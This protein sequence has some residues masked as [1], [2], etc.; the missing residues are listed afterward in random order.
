MLK[1]QESR[2]KGQGVSVARIKDQEARSKNQGKD[3]DK[4][5]VQVLSEGQADLFGVPLRPPVIYHLQHRRCAVIMRLVTGGTHG[6][7]QAE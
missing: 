3:Q 6:C 7:L 4:G 2:I 1:D 5:Q